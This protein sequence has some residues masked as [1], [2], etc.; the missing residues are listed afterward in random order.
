VDESEGD[1]GLETAS[2]GKNTGKV[3][4]VD[5]QNQTHSALTDRERI[6]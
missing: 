2:G 1:S 5:D 4:D 3:R 6:Q